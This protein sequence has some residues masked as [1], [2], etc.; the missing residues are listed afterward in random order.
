MFDFCIEH[1]LLLIYREEGDKCGY[2]VEK[3]LNLSLSEKY[4]VLKKIMKIE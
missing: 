2:V 3:Y 1:M 4:E